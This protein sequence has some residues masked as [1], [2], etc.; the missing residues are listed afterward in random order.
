MLFPRA[1]EP[2]GSVSEYP[3]W[4]G[5]LI[6][7][8]VVGRVG[9]PRRDLFWWTEDTEY[10]Q[11]RI[12]AAGFSTRWVDGA[13]VEHLHARESSRTPAW[14]VYYETRNSTYY[15]VWVQHGRNWRKLLRTYGR[16]LSRLMIDPDD[17]VAK[18]LLF[19]RAIGDGLSKRLGYR[20]PVEVRER[21]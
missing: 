18:V 5:V 15:R 19:A 9:V 21:T 3:A 20:V 14:K 6:A 8:E 11:W 7:R 17:R 12:P 16:V 2:D 13:M 10:L 4:C 1:I